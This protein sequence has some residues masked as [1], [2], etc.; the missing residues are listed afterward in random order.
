MTLFPR[1]S[2]SP[3]SELRNGDLLSTAFNVKN[4]GFFSYYNVEGECSLGKIVYQTKGRPPENTLT[5][6]S[7]PG[8]DPRFA[9]HDEE[10]KAEELAED[11][12]LDVTCPI[13]PLPDDEILTEANI[14]IVVVFRP[15]YLSWWRSER[16]YEFSTVRDANTGEVHWISR[17]AKWVKR[18]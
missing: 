5:L 3:G 9:T 8:D 13:E 18:F 2:V 12:S 16:K 17:G 7:Y 15:Y 1:M 11:G 14:G 10:F 6:Q 4:D